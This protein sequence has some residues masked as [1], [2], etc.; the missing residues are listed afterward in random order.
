MCS[1]TALHRAS[2]SSFRSRGLTSGSQ[3]QTGHPSR[4]KAGKPEATLRVHVNS[5]QTFHTGRL[6]EKCLF[7]NLQPKNTF[8]HL[9]VVKTKCCS[10]SHI[11][12][13]KQSRRKQ[14][15]MKYSIVNWL[16][17]RY[18]IK[19][20]LWSNQTL[21]GPW[22]DTQVVEFEWK[23]NS[24]ARQLP[25]LGTSPPLVGGGLGERQRQGRGKEEQI[26]SFYMNRMKLS[27]G[28]L[29]YQPNF[30]HNVICL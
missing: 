15:K 12:H 23:T 19:F 26:D 8:I 4:L 2:V 16:E 29:F 5:T 14:L 30:T 24:L 9:L 13:E 28:S 21:W 10:F 18:C 20:K 6:Q 22:F 1:G 7:S 27:W 11:L 25:L 3:S 17:I